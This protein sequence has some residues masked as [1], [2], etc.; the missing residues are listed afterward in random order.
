MIRLA[1]LLVGARALR[2]KWPVLAV[3]GLLWMS[4]G[5][6]IMSDA[7]DGV[8]VVATEAFG[9]LLAFEGFIALWF[10][11]LVPRRAS[12]SVLFRALALLVLGFMV[13]DFPVQVDVENSVLFGL[14][15]LIDGAARIVTAAVLRFSKWPLIAAGGALELAFAAIAF[16]GWPV[17]YHRTVPFCLGVALLLSGWTV[18]R[19]GLAMR[20][21]TDDTPVLRFFRPARLA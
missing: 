8:S 19:L 14:A 2:H 4:L 17:S 20:R 11:T 10:F 6:V 12:G 15:F 16:S 21:L 3:V 13:L 9:I 5:L 1:M 18:L 7:S